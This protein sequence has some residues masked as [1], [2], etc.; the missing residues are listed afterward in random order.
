MRAVAL[1]AG[2]PLPDAGDVLA[3]P[4]VSPC[5]YAFMTVIP[6]LGPWGPARRGRRPRAAARPPR[7]A[8]PARG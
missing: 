7:T 4:V 2:R 1:A 6:V 8:E 3:G 5:A